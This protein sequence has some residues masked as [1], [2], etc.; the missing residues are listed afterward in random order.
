MIAINLSGIMFNEN[1][2][3]NR[4]G[5]KQNQVVNVRHVEEVYNLKGEKLNL[6]EYALQVTTE[7]G[8]EIGWIPTLETI[9][10]YGEEAK[11]NGNKQK[12]EM[13]R[14]R[15]IDCQF[16]RDNIITDLFRNHLEVQGKICRLQTCEVT[17]AVESI[18]VMFDYM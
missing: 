4:L 8:K 12:L 18:S 17:G 3:N 15:Y 6:N 14:Q 16:I 7:L 10:K 5:L 2:D 1:L 11:A 9:Q 13:Q